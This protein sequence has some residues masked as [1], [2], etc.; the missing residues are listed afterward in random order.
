MCL[1]IVTR[2]PCP[3]L[4][5]FPSSFSFWGGGEGGRLDIDIMVHLNLKPFCLHCLLS[6][7][8]LLLSSSFLLWDGRGW[9]GRGRVGWGG[10]GGR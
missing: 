6:L 2:M 10:G 4:S 5:C 3:N 7:F 9:G 8:S 1:H